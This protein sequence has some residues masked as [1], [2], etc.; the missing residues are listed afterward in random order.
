MAV[1]R[2]LHPLLDHPDVEHQ[3]VKH[4]R[5]LVFELSQALDGRLFVQEL[6]LCIL[7]EAKGL[8]TRGQI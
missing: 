7:V 3:K 2:S 5:G 4:R 6:L 8:D 1:N